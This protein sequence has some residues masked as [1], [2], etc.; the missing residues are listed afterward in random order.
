MVVGVG[1][2]GVFRLVVW[3]LGV[4]V[5]VVGDVASAVGGGAEVGLTWWLVEVVSA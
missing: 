3:G 5:W 1:L 4:A 2:G